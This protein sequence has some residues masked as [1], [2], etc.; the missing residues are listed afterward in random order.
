L[1]RRWFSGPFSQET[2]RGIGQLVISDEL[3]RFRQKGVDLTAS[4]AAFEFLVRRGIH[5]SLGARPMKRAA[6]NSSAVPSGTP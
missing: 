1:T 5:K 3:T 2:Q 4:E 6:Q